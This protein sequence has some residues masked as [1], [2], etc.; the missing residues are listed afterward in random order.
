MKNIFEVSS[1][2][3]NLNSLI[4]QNVYLKDIWIQGEVTDYKGPAYSGH[5][6]FS[7]KDENSLIKCVFFKFAHIGSD[8]F[9]DGDK[10]LINGEIEIYSPA[11]NLQLKVRS[12]KKHGLGD[13]AIEIEKL[14]QRLDREGLFDIDRKRELPLLPQRICVI[15]SEN[16]SA[17][18]DIK[19]VFT[20]R[21]PL[22]HLILIPTLMQGDNCI[23]DVCNSIDIANKELLGD[24]I[25]LSRGGGSEEDLMPFNSEEIVR[26][27]FASKI[28]IVTG[29][30]H[31]DDNT[32]SDY[33]AD[34]R[35]LTPTG[36]AQ[37][38]S[39]DINDLR[40]E[41]NRFSLNMQK[42]VKYYLE[43]KFPEIEK[44]KIRLHNISPRK[45]EILIRNIDQLEFNLNNKL[46]NYVNTKI[47]KLENLMHS[48]NVFNIKEMS[49]KGYALVENQK[50]RIIKS[51]NQVEKGEKLKILLSDGILSSKI[52]NKIKE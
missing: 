27:I 28:P 35:G 51:I 46:S 32:L 41:I 1:L 19:K 30:G 36:A 17:W 5:K 40:I 21:Y 3:A 25:L 14:R 49:K 15:T 38:I 10:I 4:D 48:I 43:F 39:P 8:D 11:G 45:I 52:E 23:E 34:K 37:I 16:S 24:I 12:V 50:K 26:Y 6:Y 42:T 13:I 22:A 2:L 33:V 9:L 20:L 47:N 44:I 18:E 31:E 7:I 29:I